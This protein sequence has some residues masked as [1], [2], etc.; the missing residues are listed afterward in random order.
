[1]ITIR[2]G[3]S[4]Q[5][6]P[7]LFRLLRVE[8][9]HATDDM[10][11]QTSY[12]A[13][14]RLRL[15][16]MSGSLKLAPLTADWLRRKNPNG[17]IL[18]DTYEYLNSFD[19]RP[20]GKRQWVVAPSPQYRELMYRLEFGTRNMPARPHWR[21]AALEVKER[22]RSRGMALLRAVA[23]FLAREGGRLLGLKTNPRFAFGGGGAV[24]QA[25]PRR[26]RASPSHAKS[27]SLDR[28]AHAAR[29][30][31]AERARRNR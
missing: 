29:V 2:A 31:R 10:L 4:L 9:E 17:V 15:S 19:A 1:M 23:R 8:F 5:R 25:R 7:G 21:P 16:I 27:P 18:A 28:S 14:N 24:A 3:K 26:K 13:L 20:V 12:D 11:K 30:D 6:A 22:A